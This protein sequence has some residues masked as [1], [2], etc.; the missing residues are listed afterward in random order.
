MAVSPLY[1]STERGL[2]SRLFIPQQ[3]SHYAYNM[4]S[5][6]ESVLL[7]EWQHILHAGE[8]IYQEVSSRFRTAY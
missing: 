3:E 1:T 2:C 5:V 6:L 7:Q 8:H 4:W